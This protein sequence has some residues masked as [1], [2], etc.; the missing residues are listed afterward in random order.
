MEKQNILLINHY[1]GSPS[2]GMEF[3]PFF[4]AKAWKAS[5]HNTHIVAASYSHLRNVNP[6]IT[7]GKKWE[8][9]DGISFLWLKTSFYS[10]NSFGRVINMLEFIMKILFFSRLIANKVRPNIVIASSTYPLDVFPA[11]VI[12]RMTRAKL[13]YEIHDLWPLSP[14]E[15]GGYSKHHPFIFFMQIAE[16]FAYKHCDKVV[17]ILPN[18]LSHCVEHGLDP[19]K[20]IHIPNG[21]PLEELTGNRPLPKALLEKI[22]TEKKAGKFLLGYAGGHAIS[23]ALD[24]L[25]N[26]SS[27]LEPEKFHVFL[28]GKGEEKKRLFEKAKENGACVSFLDAVSKNQVQDFLHQMDA[29]YLGW[30]DL[31]LYRFGISPNK[32]VDYLLSGRMIIH[33]SNAPNDLVCEAKAGLSIPAENESALVD[34]IQKAAALSKQTRIELGICGRDYALQHL[35]YERLANDFIDFV[36]CE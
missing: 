4:M 18:T 19:K 2:H 25:I 5:G 32:L 35:N 9:I 28:L 31:A 22:E 16:N 17:S 13:V 24:T 27:R 8:L 7:S 11:W 10:G 36:V 30:R 14:Q 23:N 26:A 21:F 33:A 3:R 34:A 20:F 1:A 15:L 12:A 6:E 29:L